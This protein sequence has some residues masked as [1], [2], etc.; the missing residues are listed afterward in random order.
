[1]IYRTTFSRF[2]AE[3][4]LGLT[5]A[6]CGS[7]ELTLKDMEEKATDILKALMYKGFTFVP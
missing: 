2:L 3:N 5:R 6:L 7:L 1:M 4:S